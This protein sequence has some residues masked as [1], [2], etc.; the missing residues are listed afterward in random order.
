MMTSKVY[1]TDF[2]TT[3]EEPLPNKF[4]RLLRTSDFGNLDFKHKMVAIKLHFGEAGNMAYLRPQF[5]KVVADFIK[6]K[7][8]KP[9]L[10]DCNTLYVGSR[11]N[12]IDHLN[13]A[14]INGF[15][16]VTTGCPIIIADG[17][18]GTDDAEVPINLKHFETAHIG[19]AVVDADIIISLSHFKCHESTGIGGAIKNIGMGCGSRPG[20]MMM[21]NSGKPKVEQDDCIS[22]GTCY[23]NCAHGAIYFT[24]KK[25]AIDQDICVEC[26]YCVGTC[27]VDA[28]KPQGSDVNQ[29]LW[30]KMNEYCYA[31]LKGKQ[32]YHISIA[33]AISPFCDCHPNND[34]PIVPDIGIF[35]SADPVAI[36]CACSEAANNMPIMPQSLLAEAKSKKDAPEDIFEAL[37]PTTDWHTGLEYAES[38]GL[39]SLN[40]EIIDIDK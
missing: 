18:K 21:H 29:V 6:E 26:G 9:F 12:A 32:H 28:I 17:L 30:E 8:G 4:K 10:T 5:A 11:K 15:N 24:D 33:N 20:K 22:C 36:D 1:F 37:H 39:G 31:V 35:A 40:Y 2:R 14:E 27:P 25:A 34:Y 3:H 19:R 16:T 13:C 38:I 23:R 7:E